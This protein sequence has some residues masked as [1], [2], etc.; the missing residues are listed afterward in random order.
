MFFFALVENSKQ[1]LSISVVQFSYIER[2]VNSH[3]CSLG[4]L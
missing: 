4:I 3:I 2:E 1:L